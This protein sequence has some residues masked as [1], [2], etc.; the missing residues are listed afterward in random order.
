MGEGVSGSVAAVNYNIRFY[1]LNM[2]ARDMVREGG[3]GDIRLLSGHYLR[4]GWSKDTDWNW[5][6]EPEAGG[7]LR[8]F[9]DIGTHWVDLTSFIAGEKVD[10]GDGGAGH[11]RAERA[12][13]RLGPVETFT[14]AQGET[15]RPGD[16]DRRLGAILLRYASGARGS[17]TISQVSVGR[18]EFA[19]VGDRRVERVGGVEFGAARS[20]VDRPPRR[21]RTRCCSAIRG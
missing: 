21:G 18:Q 8:S 20:S 4:T 3:L 15:V 11:L 9:G 2:H 5:R 19:P 16:P 10:G 17:V 6:L 14:K 12:S 7:A 1:P 13:S